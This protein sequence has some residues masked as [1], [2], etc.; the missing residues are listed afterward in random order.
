MP[1]TLVSRARTADS[2]GIDFARKITEGFEPPREP[3]EK[4]GTY[5]IGCP[6]CQ[7]QGTLRSSCRLPELCLT[8]DGATRITMSGQRAADKELRNTPSVAD[9]FFFTAAAAIVVAIFVGIALWSG[10]L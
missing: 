3:G 4:P 9:V 8:C 1:E 2:N 7:G 10:A 6:R 5:T